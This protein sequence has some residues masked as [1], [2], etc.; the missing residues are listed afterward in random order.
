M[1]ICSMK[2]F[3]LGIRSMKNFV[4]GARSMKSRLVAVL[5]LAF[6]AAS[7]YAQGDDDFGIWSEVNV[8]KKIDSRW[9][10]QGGAELRTRDNSSE[11]S[12]W[13]LSADASYKMTSWLKL[14]AGYTLLRDN[15][16]KWN[17]DHDKLAEYWGTRH[18]FNTSLTG[19]LSI[20]RLDI[21]LRER[22]QYTYR[23]E[24]TVGRTN[25]NS[26]KVKDKTYNGKGK[27]AW[28]NRLMLKYKL[29]RTFR[30]YINA[31]STVARSLEKIR[32]GIGTE[33][34][35]DKHHSFDAKYI[36]QRY[37]DS[38]ADEGNFHVLGVGY[39]YKF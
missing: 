6:F 31:E 15:N 36:F 8:E 2:N 34:R 24:V 16:E 20:G 4:L 28:R 13:S 10:V 30:P 9:S 33:I 19:S 1:N 37:Y 38:D 39:T 18:R 35:L 3:V 11:L 14:S 29:T 22:W 32:Y 12:R 5:F 23:P 7:A 26:G 27:N 25:V 21:S 17:D